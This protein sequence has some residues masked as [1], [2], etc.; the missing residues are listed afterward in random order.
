M[1]VVGRML[2]E[3]RIGH[4]T[5]DIVI[6]IDT[7]TVKDTPS[8]QLLD[9]RR[10]ATLAGVLDLSACTHL[11]YAYAG[12]TSVTQI[13]LPGGGPLQ[14]IEYSSLNQYLI[15]RN[16]PLL[17]SEGVVISECLPVISDFLIENCSG[18]NPIDL[19]RSI[20]AAQASQTVHSLK[21][22][23]AVGFNETYDTDGSAVLDDLAKLADGSYV[24]L[25]S[26]GLAGS[27]PYPVLDGE[28]TIN[29]FCYEDSV[30]A[31][32][33]IFTRLTINI[34]G[35]FYIRFADPEVQRIVIDNWGDG[36]GI[37]REQMQTITDIGTKFYQNL[38]LFVSYKIKMIASIFAVLK[39]LNMEIEV[40]KT[41]VIK[42]SE[43][44]VLRRIRDGHI[45][46]PEVWL[47]YTYYLFNEIG[48]A[49]KLDKP[50]LELPEHYE[51]IDD[52]NPLNEELL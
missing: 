20:L 47:G 9:V 17:K 5:E 52:P 8:L 33:Q 46:G 25:D 34:S 38:H 44:K 7:L 28:L 2:R 42:A 13:A 29:T 35:G 6:S 41:T 4:E 10:V 18:L 48:E 24:G 26:S 19:L 12:G 16:F 40:K 14:H 31:L 50:F 15:L 30:L 51:E 27:D 1:I 3:L 39:C 22:V 11:H 23:R 36:Q 43:G 21:R 45:A 49:V 32:R 37:T